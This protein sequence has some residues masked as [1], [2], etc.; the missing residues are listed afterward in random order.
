MIELQFFSPDTSNRRE[1]KLSS[2]RWS[3]PPE[4]TVFINV[5]AALFSPSHQMGI[6]VVIRNHKGEC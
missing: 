1:T 6:G 5:D 3:L 2:P 4:G